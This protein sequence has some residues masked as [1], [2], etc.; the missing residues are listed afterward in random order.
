MAELGDDRPFPQVDLVDSIALT[1]RG[2]PILPSS[3]YCP[4]LDAILRPGK[5]LET[6]SCQLLEVSSPNGANHHTPNSSMNQ[7]DWTAMTDALT[8]AVPTPVQS[9]QEREEA[10]SLNDVVWFYRSLE[11]AKTVGRNRSQLRRS[12]LLPSPIY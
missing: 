2:K 9:L 1:N 11:Q 7:Q 12:L 8:K 3:P 5:R 4:Y 10:T 6:E